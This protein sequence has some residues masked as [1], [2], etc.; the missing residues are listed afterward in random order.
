MG[1]RSFG[2]GG[3]WSQRH[4]TRASTLQVHWQ[5]GRMGARGGETPGLQKGVT[6]PS[7]GNKR[8][9]GGDLPKVAH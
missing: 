9:E 7:P 8:P 6:I 4:G 5:G 2:K 1:V 3:K